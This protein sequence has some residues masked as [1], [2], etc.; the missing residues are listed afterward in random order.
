MSPW[1]LNIIARQIMQGATIA[2]PTDTVWGFGC[3]PL[4][5]FSISKILQLKNRSQNKGLILLS[6]NLELLKPY[7]NSTSFKLNHTELDNISETP[8]THLIKA[9][10]GCPRQITG[11]S[12]K[13]AI[14]LTT[15]PLISSLCFKI[16]SP[17]IS[18]SANISG[19]N[20]A[21]NIFIV[22]KKFRYLVDCI[23]PGYSTNK[24]NPSRVIDIETKTVIRH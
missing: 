14:R 20:T 24:N 21:R 12:E 16:Q 19:Q 1:R 18:T 22:E 7:I 3:H 13:V 15:H 2:Y 8:T 11:I 10:Q 5:S 4:S 9:S 23:I 17:I 6:P